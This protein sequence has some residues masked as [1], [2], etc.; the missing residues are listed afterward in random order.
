MKLGIFI[1][2]DRH[3]EHI[4]GITKAAV[5]KGHEVIMFNMDDGV[6]LL[7][8]P[9]FSELCGTKGVSISFCDY[10]TI[11]LGIN[12]KGIPGEVICGSQYNNA[13]MVREVDRLIVL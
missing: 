12:K 10:S 2:N 3:L 9:E 13:L 11:D 4:V 8:N 1:N 5:F 6:K 7:G